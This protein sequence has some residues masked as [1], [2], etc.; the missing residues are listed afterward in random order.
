[1]YS[2]SIAIREFQST[3]IDYR[4][5]VNVFHRSVHAIPDVI[6]SK[7]QKSAWAPDCIDG[8]SWK[9]R[10]EEHSVWVAVDERNQ[11][12]LGFIELNKNGDIECLYVCPRAQ[13][14]GIAKL[15]LITT[16]ESIRKHYPDK[17]QWL[18]QASDVAYE[19]FIKHGFL[20]T[21]RNQVERF[22]VSLENTT[23]AKTIA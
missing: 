21:K 10:L 7:E 5:L 19:F 2:T 22:G 4:A 11:E 17:T 6:Y 14:Q 9:L 15:L 13:R 16:F 20:P 8:A 23:M 18:V 1:M 3:E 12:P